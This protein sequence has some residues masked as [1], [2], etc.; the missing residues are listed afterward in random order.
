M[1]SAQG[2]LARDGLALPTNPPRWIREFIRK[3]GYAGHIH[4]AHAASRPG[5]AL[6]R[7]AAFGPADIQGTGVPDHRWER[8]QR[9]QCCRPSG[10][11]NDSN[12]PTQ[13]T[14][15][16]QRSNAAVQT[17][18]ETTAT[19]QRCCGHG[20][21]RRADQR[22]DNLHAHHA[23]NHPRRANSSPCRPRVQWVV[24]TAPPP[25]FVIFRFRR[26]VFRRCSV[27]RE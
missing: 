20:A 26:R 9:H 10:P 23:E 18:T 5:R 6:M 16:R 25:G 21:P 3:I 8:Q 17:S 12:G 11:R 14:Q 22:V 15:R 24:A 4:R 1:S 2:G 19:D 27:F 7:Q 13:H